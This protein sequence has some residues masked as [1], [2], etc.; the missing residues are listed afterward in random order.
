MNMTS[1]DA[2][3]KREVEDAEEVLHNNQTSPHGPI[4]IA[5]SAFH[6]S[7]AGT[8]TGVIERRG[9]YLQF[10]VKL[11]DMPDRLIFSPPA[12]ERQ[13]RD[14][15]WQSTCLEFF[16]QPH[17]QESYVEWNLSPEGDWA[18]YEFSRYRERV[19]DDDA[20]CS[21]LHDVVASPEYSAN[22]TDRTMQGS[23]LLP[24]D[25]ACNVGVSMVLAVAGDEAKD[26][27]TVALSYWALAHSGAQPDF[28]RSADWRVALPARN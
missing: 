26:G 17:G 4:Q 28:H 23:V 11:R 24:T 6:P 19:N 20:A 7:T 9:R 16:I 25:G 1:G 12:V 8:V 2:G 18:C 14:L 10:D 27:G 22:T 13:R 3:P 5:L 21:M 15:L